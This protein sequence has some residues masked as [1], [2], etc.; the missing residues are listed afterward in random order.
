VR[1][2]TLLAIPIVGSQLAHTLTTAVDTAFVGRL[3]ADELAGVGLAGVWLWA[4]FALFVGTAT[5][6]QTFVAQADGAGERNRCGAWAWQALIALVPSAAIAAGIYGWGLERLLSTIELA[7]ALAEVAGDYV[8]MRLPG[9]VF[10]IPAM[11][12]ASFYRGIGDAKTPLYLGIASNLLNVLLDWALIFGHLGLPE[13]GVRGAG[14]ATTISHAFWSLGSLALFLSMPRLRAYG[15]A[16]NRLEPAMLP[17]YLRTAS[18]IG[19]QWVIGALSFSGWTA[20]VASIGSAPMA[21]SQITMM[22]MNLSFMPAYGLSIAVATLAGRYQGAR[23]P[24]AVRRSLRNALGLGS[25]FCCLVAAALIGIPELLFELFTTDSNVIQ[26]AD[27]MLMM[28]ALFLA[29]DA[30]S[31]VVSGA[32]RG[33]GD[34]RFPFLVESLLSWTI[35]LPGGWL[36]GIYLDGGVLGAWLAALVH[37]VLLCLGVSLRFRSGAWRRAQI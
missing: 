34:T 24:E 19:A 27:E 25:V 17:R 21:A 4:G 23:D 11:V 26:L 1:E 10:A 29:F 7:P 12:I 18:P 15:A 9:E 28:G 14:I 36:L 20:I 31:I 16:W 5:G 22:L 3:G 2:V 35:F 33:T 32:L 13:L 6:V 37:V 30:A 8:Q